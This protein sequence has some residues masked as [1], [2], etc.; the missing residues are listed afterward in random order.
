MRD[1]KTMERTGDEGLAISVILPDGSVA[2]DASLIFRR[3]DCPLKFK[4]S[5][6]TTEGLHLGKFQRMFP[7]WS[8]IPMTETTPALV[9]N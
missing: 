3:I 9:V 7:K 6:V 2:A 5:S 8:Y 1:P 4:Q